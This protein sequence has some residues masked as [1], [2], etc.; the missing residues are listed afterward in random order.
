MKPKEIRELSESE[1][2]KK[3]RDSREELMQI[4]LH[5]NTGQMEQSHKLRQL[6]RE[7]A[8]LE[9]IHREKPTAAAGA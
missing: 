9:T 4:R 7:I 5:K 1:I 3:I 8:R 2:Q 6:R